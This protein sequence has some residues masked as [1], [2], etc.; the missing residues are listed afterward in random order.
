[1]IVTR[2]LHRGRG[3]APN[4]GFRLDSIRA[5]KYSFDVV[6]QLNINMNIMFGKPEKKE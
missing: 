3:K 6:P 4:L 2:M 1:M 5:E